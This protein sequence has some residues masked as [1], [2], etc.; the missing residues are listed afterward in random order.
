M[1]RRSSGRTRPAV[2]LVFGESINDSASIAHLLVA[3]NPALNGRVR[4]LPR[5]ASLTREARPPA[6]ATWVAKLRRAV[7]AA[8][9]NER[10]AAVVVHRDADGPDPQAAVASQLA[11]QLAELDDHAVVPVQAIEAW[12]FLFPDAVEAVRPGAW[13]GKLPR[14]KQDVELI[15]HP[16]AA[17][18]R[19]TR[20]RNGLEYTEAESP[21]IAKQIRDGDLQPLCDCRSYDRFVTTARGIG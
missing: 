5:P 12:W 9:A 3:A 19:A 18:Q 4:P 17:L 7:L 8:K 21:V 20:T 2:I 14:R 13:R 11:R 6:V 16:K 10:V 1:P 15:E